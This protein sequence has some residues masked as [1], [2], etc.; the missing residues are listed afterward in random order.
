MVEAFMEA[1]SERNA[2][3]VLCVLVEAEGSTPRKTGAYMVVDETGRVQGTIGGGSLEHQAICKGM[4]VIST[5]ENDKIN[6]ELTESS[7]LGMV[8]GGHGTVIFYYFDPAKIE[9]QEWLTKAMKYGQDGQDYW[10]MIP[11]DGSSILVTKEG[12]R[13]EQQRSL[14]YYNRLYYKEHFC[15]D[16]LV[17]V[18]GGGHLAQ[19][20]V[21]LLS[22]LGFTCMVCDDRQEFAKK[23]LFLAAKDVRVVDY[24][25]LSHE[26]EIKEKDYIIIITRGHLGDVAVERFALTTPAKYIGVV[27]SKRKSAK[28]RAILEEE[29]YLAEVLDR[30]TTPIG[31]PIDSETPAEIAVSIAAQLIQVRAKSKKR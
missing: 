10:V 8:C 26:Y 5:K 9:D 3:A 1:L 16:G 7:E 27:G 19:E 31:I 2:P 30:V 4:E 29:G 14:S 17:Y 11:W 24:E 23:E 6:F 21:P 20:T 25:N 13:G 18:F 12:D 28:V 22:H 15:Y